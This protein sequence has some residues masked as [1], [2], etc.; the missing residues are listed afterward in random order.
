MMYAIFITPVFDVFTHFDIVQLYLFHWSAQRE[1][2]QN[3]QLVVNGQVFSQ[4]V[5]VDGCE[6]TSTQSLFDGT[7]QHA[8]AG[9][10]MVAKEITVNARVPH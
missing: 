6:N 3:L 10:A 7:Q 5:P 1:H 4:T 2:Q 9:D 8:L